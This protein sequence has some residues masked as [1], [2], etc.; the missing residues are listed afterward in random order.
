MRALHWCVAFEVE[1]SMTAMKSFVTTIPSSLFFA[2]F[3]G[4]RLCSMIFMREVGIERLG[5]I[6]CVESWDEIRAPDAAEAL[7]DVAALLGLV[8]EEVLSLGELVAWTLG[9]EDGFE[10]VGVVARVPGLGGDG[11]RRGGEVLHLFEVEVE[12]LGDDG[13]L[14]HVLLLTAGVGGDEVGDDLLTEPFLAVDAVE[15]SLELVE[16]LEG[17]LAHEVEHAV[18]GVLWRHFQAPADV[19]GDEFAG[20]FLGSTVGGFVLATM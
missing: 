20:V 5:R 16:L 18:A 6:A 13:E 15:E 3:F 2:G 19:A 10:G 4:V 9:G 7:F 11:H 1:P 17:G 14:C 8:P 12:A